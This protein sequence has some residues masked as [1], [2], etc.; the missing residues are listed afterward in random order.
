LGRR[1][2]LVRFAFH[3]QLYATGNRSVFGADDI[4][5]KDNRVP[6]TG[7]GLAV[8]KSIVEAHGGTIG[9]T[10]EVG[11]GSVFTFSL[12]IVLAAKDAR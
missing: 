6:G 10:S 9:V 12:P 4:L 11:R 7:M 1:T 5:A 3:L 2:L 8:A